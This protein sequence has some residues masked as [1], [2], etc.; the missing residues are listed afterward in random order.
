MVAAVARLQASSDAVRRLSWN[1]RLR[2]FMLFS[3]FASLEIR[4]LAPLVAVVLS[5]LVDMSRRS[6]ARA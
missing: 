1:T 2:S 4:R 5:F 6:L 3:P